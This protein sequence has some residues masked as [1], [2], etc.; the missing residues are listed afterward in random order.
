[1]KLL[2]LSIITVLNLSNTLASDQDWALT[3]YG[4]KIKV[5]SPEEPAIVHLSN[6][7]FQRAEDY[8]RNVLSEGLDSKQTRIEITSVNLTSGSNES[9]QVMNDL[10]AG[11]LT[12]TSTNITELKHIQRFKVK[13][14]RLRNDY[15][16]SLMV[17]VYM[18]SQ[19]SCAEDDVVIARRIT[20]L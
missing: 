17:E 5:A 2:L 9:I 3:K 19:V 4:T 18:N 7:C 16:E 1:M 13:A 8:T 20:I 14:E 11:D 15:I 10:Q 6:N 12:F